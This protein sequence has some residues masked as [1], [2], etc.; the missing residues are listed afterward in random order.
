M[1]QFSSIRIH[2]D[3]LRYFTIQPALA[4][5]SL[6]AAGLSHLLVSQENNPI[7]ALHMILQ[8][9]GRGAVRFNDGLPREMPNAFKS[10]GK[11]GGKGTML[12]IMIIIIVRLPVQ[13]ARDSPKKSTRKKKADS[14]SYHFYQIV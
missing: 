1:I 2:K 7:E 9:D 13:F 10:E 5:A 6:I 3:L 14:I 12:H 11:R 8:G 4:R